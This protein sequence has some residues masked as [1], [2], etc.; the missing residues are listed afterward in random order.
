MSFDGRIKWLVT[1]ELQTYNRTTIVQLDSIR[2][3][4]YY[5]YFHLRLLLSN[6]LEKKCLKFYYFF[7]HFKS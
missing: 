6:H 3:N 2:R 1:T 5:F 4:H 7:F